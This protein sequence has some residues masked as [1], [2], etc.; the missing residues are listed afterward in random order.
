MSKLRKGNKS[1]AL[2]NGEWGAH[3]RK[4]GKFFTAKVRRN[5]DKKTIKNEI[6]NEL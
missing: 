3:M 4:W 2:L 5:V 6:K 1:N